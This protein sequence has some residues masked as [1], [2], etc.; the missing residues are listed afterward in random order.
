MYNP[1][2]TIT[3]KGPIEACC[4]AETEIMKKVREAYDNDMAAMNV[5]Q[6]SIKLLASNSLQNTMVSH[7][8]ISPAPWHFRFPPVFVDFRSEKRTCSHCHMHS[9]YHAFSDKFLRHLPASCLQQQTHLIPGLNLGALGLFPPSGSMPPPP[10][11]NSAS[12]YGSFG[13]SAQAFI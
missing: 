7:I 5:S 12:P 1:E 10:S 4:L 3:V 8:D 9:N 11:G 2:R 13:V 6:C